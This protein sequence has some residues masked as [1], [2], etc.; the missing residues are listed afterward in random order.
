MK[1]KLLQDYCQRL[2]RIPTDDRE[3]AHMTADELLCELLTTLG[4][5]AV[6]QAWRD[7]PKWYA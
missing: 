1:T 6:V 7:V 4:Y 5:V 3:G 2:N